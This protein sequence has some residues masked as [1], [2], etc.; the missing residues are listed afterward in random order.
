[1]QLPF[2]HPLSTVRPICKETWYVWDITQD[3]IRCRIHSHLFCFA[4]SSMLPNC[5]KAGF[6]SNEVLNYFSFNLAVRD[7]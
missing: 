5:C 7:Q 4:E 3:M 2:Y 6:K 1:M